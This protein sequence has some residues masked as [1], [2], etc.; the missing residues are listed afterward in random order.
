MS[1]E[2]MKSRIRAQAQ[3]L[4]AVLQHQC[5]EGQEALQR[6]AA[7]LRSRKQILITGM[8]ASFYAS[9]PLETY[10]CSLGIDAVAVEAGELLHFRQ[11]AFR[12][13]A[14]LVVSRSG[15]SIEITKLLALLKGRQPVVGVSNKPQSTL[16]RTADAAISIASLDDDIVALQTYTG[17]LLALALLGG[18]IAE[19]FA[20][21]RAQA[22][23]LLPAFDRLVQASLDG[24]QAWDA[25]L[26]PGSAI[27]LLARGA[28]FAT[29]LEGALLFHEVAKY[30]A[31]AMPTAS[32]RHG[33]VEVV[34]AQ[35]RAFLASPGGPTHA[36]DLALARDIVRCGGE[37]RVLGPE[38]SAGVASVALPE[39]PALL[40]PISEVVPLQVAALRLAELRGVVPGSFRIA[41]PVALDE[42]SFG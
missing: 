1:S 16:A 38:G 27:Y 17:T 3:S 21:M 9:L 39:V 32:F 29:A 37:V 8:G 19:Q 20:E 13:A 28:S 42:A 18:A 41:P 35:F 23:A 7:L 14:V 4:T 26:Q 40:A 11:A 31:V 36:L 33:P 25:F 6:A 34:D 5:G 22:E 12:D 15:E 30:P 24:V 2:Q 10:L